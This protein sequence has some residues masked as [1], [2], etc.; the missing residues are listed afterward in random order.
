MHFWSTNA[1]GNLTF[2]S[3]L[4]KFGKLGERKE[5]KGLRKED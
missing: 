2:S 3:L 5:R 4:Q 1:C